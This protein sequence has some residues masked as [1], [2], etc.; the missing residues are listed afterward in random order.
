[1]QN[2][3]KKLS[4]KIFTKD[5]ICLRHEQHKTRFLSPFL[6]LKT[7]FFYLIWFWIHFN[8]SKTKID[9]SKN[10]SEKKKQKSAIRLKIK[11]VLK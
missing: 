5:L 3:K 9:R 11:I 2:T 1:M 8:T 10:S 4:K 7:T 6:L